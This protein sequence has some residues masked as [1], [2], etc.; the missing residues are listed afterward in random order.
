MILKI[1]RKKE[2]KY[3]NVLID[4]EDFNKIKNYKWYIEINRKNQIRSVLSV[5]ISNGK[6][7]TIR[8]HS[9]ILNTNKIID[10][11]DLNVLNNQ[12]NNLRICTHK[13]NL[14]NRNIF[15]NN[16]SGYKGVVFIKK[17]QKFKAQIKHDGI[18][19][20]IGY[21]NTKEEA[22]IAYNLKANFYFKDFALLNNIK[23][24]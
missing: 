3:Y 9:L 17:I 11:K 15:K 8:M 21:F 24:I 23:K 18:Q 13:Q 6:K 14:C 12:K 7:K 16:S 2:N 10:H 19:E 1:L 20:Y 22:A 5:F 4:D